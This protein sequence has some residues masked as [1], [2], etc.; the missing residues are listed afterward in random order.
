[1]RGLDVG[2]G[3]GQHAPD[4]QGRPARLVGKPVAASSPVEASL[5]FEYEIARASRQGW[6]QR[7]FSIIS[8]F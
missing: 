1:V 5:T 6:L 2:Q 3:Q 7:F 8:P 4:N